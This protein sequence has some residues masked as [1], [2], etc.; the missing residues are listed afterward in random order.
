MLSSYICRQCRIQ[1]IRRLASQRP[2]PR[3]PLSNFVSLRPARNAPDAPRRESDDTPDNA[4]SRP[5]P[6]EEHLDREPR[7]RLRRGRYADL[8]FRPNGQEGQDKLHEDDSAVRVF[9]EPHAVRDG[10]SLI[11]IGRALTDGNLDEAW[12][13][14]LHLYPSK[15]CAALTDP[16][17]S[18]SNLWG[19][20]KI[21]KRLLDRIVVAYTTG[22]AVPSTPSMVLFKYE[23]LDLYRFATQDMGYLH[24][25]IRDVL[26]QYTIYLL[27]YSSSAHGKGPKPDAVLRE[28]LAVWR[29]VFQCRGRDPHAM[30]EL[31]AQWKFL[32]DVA[33]VQKSFADLSHPTNIANRME[34]WLPRLSFNPEIAFSATAAFSMLNQKSEF[35]FPMS[36]SV[37]QEAAPFLQFMAHILSNGLSER[38]LRSLE[39]HSPIYQHASGEIQETIRRL[40]EQAPVDAAIVIGAKTHRGKRLTQTEQSSNLELDLLKR[41]AR[42]VQEHSHKSRLERLWT[43]AVRGFTNENN[44]TT[45]PTTVYNAF[46][47]GFL[48]LY[49]KEW[50]I[51]VWNHMIAHKINP[52]LKSWTA[53]LSG[54]ERGRDLTGLKTIWDRM[55]RSGVQPDAFAWTAY[56]HGLISLRALNDGLVAMDQMGKQWLATQETENKAPAKGSKGQAKAEAKE[57]RPKPTIEVVNGAISAIAQLRLGNQAFQRKIRHVQEILA[58][59]SQFSIRPDA[60]TYNTLI[61]LYLSGSD[62]QTVFKLLNQ[63][64]ADGIEADMATYTML[65]RSAFENQSFSGL[66]AEEQAQRVMEIFDELESGGLELNRYLYSSTIDRLLKQYSNFEAVRAV[67]EHMISRGLKPNHHIFTPLM[68]HYFKQSPPD[69]EAVD[70]LWYMITNVPGVPTDKVL[71]DRVIE[72]YASVGEIGKMMAVLITMSKHGKLPGWPALTAVVKAL[73][74]GGEWERALNVVKD[75]RKEEGLLKDGVGGNGHGQEHFWHV[76]QSL[77]LLDPE[78]VPG[79][80]S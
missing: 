36:E 1:I 62:Y 16:P 78:A 6:V 48:T 70:S 52:N 39:T 27:Q 17:L 45:I 75:V 28:M 24:H 19:G 20:G 46:L 79:V 73:A 54:C 14:L 61:Q 77:G 59:A 80:D 42:A 3:R 44:K 76:V 74:A 4:V 12:S 8:V 9:H 49:A 66:A 34:F 23:Q 31:D 58:W 38:L 15:D 35:A 26:R 21:F 51:E 67:M 32:P 7:Q 65:I 63:M 43:E 72:G 10:A 68:T 60:I 55:M 37:L 5:R 40:V 57:K 53:M 47:Q 69:I 18:Q 33:E 41:I 30:E 29:V 13:H 71:F 11:S 2:S 25:A 56:V 22:A 50:S 64:E